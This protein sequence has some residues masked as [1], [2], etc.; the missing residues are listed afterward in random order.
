MLEGVAS[1]TPIQTSPIQAPDGLVSKIKYKGICVDELRFENQTPETV[2]SPETKIYGRLHFKIQPQGQN[3]C[4]RQI[5]IGIKGYGPQQFILSERKI[6]GKRL[7]GFMGVDQYQRVYESYTDY[8][9]DFTLIAPKE[10]G[11]YEVEVCLVELVGEPIKNAGTINGF[12]KLKE[13]DEQALQSSHA[14][15]HLWNM[16]ESHCRVSMGRIR[17]I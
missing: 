5:L 15:A 8:P 17:V 9:K 3:N 4:L 11:L 16:T 10:I 13:S 7:E 14:L 1:N 2:V 6:I 12:F